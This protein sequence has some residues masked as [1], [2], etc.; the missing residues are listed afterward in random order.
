M[1]AASLLVVDDDR[2]ALATLAAGL[3]S[4]GYAVATA[5][6]G[7]AALGL[8][9]N[10]TFDLAVLDIRM[11]G[12]SGIQLAHLLRER[13]HLPS[14]Y[15]SAYGEREEVLEAISEGGLGYLVKPVDPINLVPAIE[16]ALARA[17]D[18]AE[19]TETKAQ[20][21]R[22]LAGDRSTSTAV[23]IL[24]AQNGI[25]ERAAFT[26]LRGEARRQRRRIDEHSAM[27]VAQFEPHGND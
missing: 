16:A 6:S 19:L 10:H 23:G 14:L 12:L 24:M 7:E 21:E 8:T 22:A 9:A 3:R 5:C 4:L 17:R 18:L 15:L 13:F 26:A 20:L 27:L 25:S 2:L 1:L 11:P